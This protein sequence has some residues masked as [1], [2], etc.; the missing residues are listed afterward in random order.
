MTPHVRLNINN[1]EVKVSYQDPGARRAVPLTGVKAEEDVVQTLTQL[2]AVS[3]GLLPPAMRWISSSGRQAIF[4]RPPRRVMFNYSPKNMGAEDPKVRMISIEL[5]WTVYAI[6]CSQDWFVRQV[7]L[8]ASFGPLR[9]SNDKV[10]MMPLPNTYHDGHF[11]LPG[12]M[13]QVTNIAEAFE[14]SYE[15]LWMGQF[16]MDIWDLPYASLTS[17]HPVAL[18]G[19]ADIEPTKQKVS[20][21]LTKWETLS[22]DQVLDIHDWINQKTVAHVINELQQFNNQMFTGTHMMTT[23]K[24]ALYHLPVKRQNTQEED[25][26]EEHS[27]AEAK[28]EAEKYEQELKE[29]YAAAG[30][31]GDMDIRTAINLANAVTPGDVITAQVYQGN[32]TW[33]AMGEDGVLRRVDETIDGTTYTIRVNTDV[34]VGNYTFRPEDAYRIERTE[35]DPRGDLPPG[36]DPA[37][38]EAA[39]RIRAAINQNP[40][41]HVTEEML[42][43]A[44]MVLPM[45]ERITEIVQHAVA[46]P[47]T[48]EMHATFG[49]D[50][51]NLVNDVAAQVE[52]MPLDQVIALAENLTQAGQLLDEQPPEEA[53]WWAD[54]VEVDEEPDYEN[55]D[56]YDGDPDLDDADEDDIPF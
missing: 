42:R 22:Q 44:G 52:E 15:R 25:A 32:N 28:A 48:E 30:V 33:A 17:G 2:G 45:A 36:M 13:P 8:Y 5:P 10:A 19:K 41:V 29:K 35:P 7:S 40:A 23:V 14:Q 54:R 16:N 20:R 38:V 47:T 12:G 51:E 18:L 26:E 6:S 24:T 1:G 4:E 53:P 9:S 21:M 46:Q 50:V 55:Y 3:S 37:Q 11:C 49:Q 43:D 34:A 31:A 56:E 27:R 39:T